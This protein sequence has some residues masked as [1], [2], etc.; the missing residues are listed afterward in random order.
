MKRRT[1]PVLL[2]LL[3]LTAPAAV[4]AQFDYTTNA[5]NTLT[6]TY[7]YWSGGNVTIPA[8]INGLTVTS[9]GEEA[10][11]YCRTLTSVTIPA[12]V[13]NIGTNAFYGCSS[14]VSVTIPA[15]VISIGD[16]AFYGCGLTNVMIPGS[17]TSIG[18]SAFYDC[19][20]VTGLTNLYFGGNGALC[21]SDPQR[22]NYPGRYYRISSP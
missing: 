12:S 18:D 22:A 2:G 6:I 9:I 7:Y 5:D 21:F 17:V 10:F 13:T 14:L 1:W 19:T 20:G 8:S 16:Y 15:S 4:Q 3:L 11:D